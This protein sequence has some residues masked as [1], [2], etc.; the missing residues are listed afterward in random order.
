[1]VS[2][3]LVKR[4]WR[5]RVSAPSSISA[6]GNRIHVAGGGVADHTRLMN[7]VRRRL[8]GGHVVVQAY[9]MVIGRFC[10]HGVRTGIIGSWH[11]WK[12]ASLEVGII[13]IRQLSSQMHCVMT[14]SPTRHATKSVS[15]SAEQPF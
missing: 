3:P 8:R 11:H 6:D 13:G 1:M 14:Y 4:D 5:Y 2:R 9:R 15:S 10:N 7:A 12:V